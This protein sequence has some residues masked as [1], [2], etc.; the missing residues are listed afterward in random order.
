MEQGRDGYIDGINHMDYIVIVGR[1]FLVMAKK[2]NKNSKLTKDLEGLK[3]S[4]KA[5]QQSL[6]E[7]E[8]QAEHLNSD[9]NPET[10]LFIFRRNGH[11]KTRPKE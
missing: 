4:I 1:R 2:G 7:V 5:V 11:A 10:R 8:L 6:H 9:I 3:K